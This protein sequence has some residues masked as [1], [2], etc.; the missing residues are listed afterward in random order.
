MCPDGGDSPDG[1]PRCH[2]RPFSSNSLHSHSPSE[3]HPDPCYRRQELQHHAF[4]F[5][6]GHS[7]LSPPPTAMVVAA[8]RTQSSPHKPSGGTWPKVIAGAPASDFTQLSIYKRV[9]Q[10]KSIF[11][12]NAFRRPEPPPK[13]DYMSLSQMPKH[14]PQQSSIAESAQAPPT[15]PARSDSFRF[16]HRQQNSSASDSTITTCTPPASPSQSTAAATAAPQD[17]VE[18]GNQLYYSDAPAE[19][20]SRPSQE[21][22]SRQRA[23]D[24]GK[25]RYRP[26]SAPALRRNV[27][28]IHIPVPMQV[29][30]KCSGLHCLGLLFL[31]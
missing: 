20:S 7:D 6:P 16:K 21:E 5:A 19:E 28:P 11:E 25:R 27:T 8:D 29:S 26:K 18:T 1:G 13:L 23:E 31:K 15:P 14:S 10:R 2:Q 30:H 3:P 4:T 12:V 9:K 17:S 22:R 24:R